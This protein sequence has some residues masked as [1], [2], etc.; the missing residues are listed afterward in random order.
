MFLGSGPAAVAEIRT[1]ARAKGNG[2]RWRWRGYYCLAAAIP[3]ALFGLDTLFW[4]MTVV[5]L[6][7]SRAAA[8]EYGWRNG[9]LDCKQQM[10]ERAGGVRRG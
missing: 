9:Y 5:A 7:C 8:G 1:P 2:D 3:F 4:S 6:A 10:V